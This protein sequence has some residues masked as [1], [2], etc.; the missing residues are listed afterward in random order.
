MAPF[1]TTPLDL[2]RV[3]RNCANAEAARRDDA[4]RVEVVHGVAQV[5]RLEQHAGDR[6]RK[7]FNGMFGGREAL[8]TMATFWINSLGVWVVDLTALYLAVFVDISFPLVAIY[9]PLLNS[10]GHVVPALLKRHYNPGLI[11]AVL[12]FIPC[13]V[14]SLYWIHRAAPQTWQAHALGIALAFAIHAAII[15]YVRIRLSR[16]SKNVLG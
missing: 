3:L 7:F 1:W 9:L 5:V 13:R 2:A 16:L 12:L 15:V 6:F 8:T 10:I 11:T 4:T 14:G